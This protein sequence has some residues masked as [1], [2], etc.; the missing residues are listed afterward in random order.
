MKL[1]KIYIQ[2]GRRNSRLRRAILLLLLKRRWI[3]TNP[4]TLVKL[5]T[6]SSI[7]K[8][9]TSS[10]GRGDSDLLSLLEQGIPIIGRIRITTS[11]LKSYDQTGQM[12]SGF[13]SEFRIPHFQTFSTVQFSLPLVSSCFSQTN[14]WHHDLQSLMSDGIQ[15]S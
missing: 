11:L 13:K 8:S 4:C 10:S 2:Y 15:L 1:L 14:N 12:T 5:L 9:M 3:I 6:I 7:R